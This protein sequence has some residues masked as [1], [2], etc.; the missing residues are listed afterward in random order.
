MMLAGREIYRFLCLLLPAVLLP[1]MLLLGGAAPVAAQTA[2]TAP[3]PVKVG[4]VDM[5]ILL[6][7]SRAVR[8]IVSEVDEEL[9]Q[10]ARSIEEKRLEMEGLRR[11]LERQSAVLS[12]QERRRRQDQVVVLR[13]EIE[14]L[15]FS[16]NRKLRD[17][18]RQ[19]INPLLEE[20][21]K[22]VADVGRR[23]GYDLI[24]RGEVV[25]Y[26]SSS[27]DLTPLVIEEMDK[28]IDRLRRAAARPVGSGAQR[29]QPLS[30]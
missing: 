29:P 21:I 5:E 24:V 8:T 1:A 4:F 28:Q 3:A 14:E 30:P 19:T 11:D 26:G 25:L 18:Q 13:G 20:V 6:D 23:E 10:Q 17:Q 15:E 7:Q 9:A 12:D 2:Q 22:I 16:F 27:V